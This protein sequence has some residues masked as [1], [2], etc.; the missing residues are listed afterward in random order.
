[1]ERPTVS[2]SPDHLMVA[3]CH[4]DTS[5]VQDLL[6]YPGVF[7]AHSAFEECECSVPDDLRALHIFLWCSFCTLDISRL[8]GNTFVANSVG[9]FR[10]TIKSPALFAS[11]FRLDGIDSLGHGS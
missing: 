3:R 6:C 7:I 9:D 1:M 11:K 5:S 10:E 2:S 8:L 4:H